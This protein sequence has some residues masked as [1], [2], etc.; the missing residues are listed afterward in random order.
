MTTPNCPYCNKRMVLRNSA[1]GSF[2][3][4]SGF[5]KCRGTR[6]MIKYPAHIEEKPGTVFNNAI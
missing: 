1:R 5:P 4:C 6:D 3:G 2:Y